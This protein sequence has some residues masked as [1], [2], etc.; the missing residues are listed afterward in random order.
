MNIKDTT[1]IIDHLYPLVSESMDKNGKKFLDNISIFFNKN[2]EAIHNIAPYTIIYFN[3]DD[4]DKMFNSLKLTEEQVIDIIKNC[5]FYDIN[6]TPLA[7]KD[8]T[9]EVLMCIIKYYIDKG[10]KQKAVL[11][12]IYTL[13]TGKF[14]ASLFTMFWQ[15]G[16]NKAIMD[17]VINNMLS[18]KFDLKKEGTI[19]KAMKKLAETFITK[20]YNHF[21]KAKIT[22]DQF[23]K[24]IQQLRDREKSFLNNIA[25]AY[26]EANENKSYMNYE[27]QLDDENNFRLTNNDAAEAARITQS[28]MGI[29]S[30]QKVD[31]QLCNSASTLVKGNIK[32][33]QIKDI[34]ENILSDKNNFK[35]LGNL[36]NITI[37][38]YMEDPANKGQR[39][40][41]FNFIRE[42]LKATPN[43]K[44]VY[45]A[46]KK[47]IL[48]DFLNRYSTR[49]RNTTNE[50]TRNDML[51]AVL[52]YIVLVICKV[53]NNK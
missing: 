6:Y 49:Y 26:Y 32:S 13:F 1:V 23:G 35:D 29:L 4:K 42:A 9:V 12:T 52:G 11:T 3:K 2:H 5:F 14:Y 33:N 20:Y 40:G 34:M 41:S 44:N 31:A 53:C 7:A 50:G 18:D 21:T 27:F 47:R 22:D 25:S 10:D 15:Y 43:T 24:H 38:L 30:S 45:L 46:E 51:K 17:Y 48:V 39:V 8:A 28:T 19:F 16:V 37:C 36:I